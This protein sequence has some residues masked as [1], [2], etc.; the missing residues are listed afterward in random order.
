MINKSAEVSR[1]CALYEHNS[2]HYTD[3]EGTATQTDRQ[4]GRRSEDNSQSILYNIK[5]QYDRLNGQQES[6]NC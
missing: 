2:L 5:Q 6:I 4:T 1:K 3:P